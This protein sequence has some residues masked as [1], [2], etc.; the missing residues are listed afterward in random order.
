V[1]SSFSSPCPSG[2]SPGSAWSTILVGRR[3]LLA[4][5]GWLIV[6]A[7]TVG[8]FV[9]GIPAEF[10]QLQLGCPTLAC[11]STGG[12]TPVELPLLENL[13]LSPDLFAAYGVALEVI[14]ASVFVAV[15][16]LIFWRKSSDK[17]ALFV[18]LALL[19]FG[20]ATQPIAPEA[21]TFTQPVWRLPVDVLHF[22]GSACFSLFLYLFPDGRFVPRWTRWVALVWIA[23]LLPRYWFP[24]WPPSGSDT[25]LAW[26]N[27]IVW[28]SA[29]GTAVYSQAYRYRHISNTV[30]R[31]QTK[32][33]VFGIATA[34]TLFLISNLVVSAIALQSPTS[35][36]ALAELMIGAVLM[37]GALLLIPLSIGIAILRYHLFDI[38]ILINRTLVYGA[39][40]ISVVGIYV[41]VVG[42]LSL[43][44]RA[45]GG[46][47]QLVISV[48]ATGLVALLFQ[49]LRNRLQRGINRL[50]YGERDDPYAVL[51]RL[52]Q[53]LEATLAPE[54]VLPTIV[55]TV[56]ESLKLP[57]TAITLKQDDTFTVA[58]ASGIP[59]DET[60]RLPLVYQNEM[61]GQLL[62][63]QRAPGEIFSS[64]DRRLLDDLAREAGVAVHA[65]RLTTHLQRMTADLQRSREHLVNTREEERRR[66]RRDLHDGLGP[67]LASL[68]QLIDTARVLVA[69]DPDAAVTLLGD[70]KDQ[71][72]VTIT[73][74]RRLVYALR[75]PVL[76][77]LGL[78]SAIGEHIGRYNQ[79]NG[80]QVLFDAPNHLPLLPA[81][82]EVAA[83]HIA[84]EALT[85]VARHANAHTCRIR[86]WLESGLCLE[87][88]DDGDGMPMNKHAGVGLTSMR[89]RAA[90]LG[91][92]FKIEPG[93]T[94]GTRVRARLPLPME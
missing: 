25:W 69:R 28:L 15:A 2:S 60:L 22:L 7:L 12:A 42:Y 81:A 27:L 1:F 8:L 89:E 36:G 29:L 59:V 3:L 39:L 56:K 53:R 30:Q 79:P 71:I 92:E 85:N 18:S 75:P 61:V 16:A 9:A 78:V 43:L 82:V 5:A 87:I 67:T 47:S 24:D 41:L 93:T 35:T 52:G 55:E 19:L 90:E 83:Y 68:I 77:E 84:L 48:L 14:F 17:V 64:A 23:W 13:G 20:T 37:Y 46:E 74:I 70:V 49:P 34:L 10:A 72:K 57:Y 94:H 4:R 65:V 50:M 26:A 21:L 91:G 6:G 11:A 44:F 73:D 63:A 62:L 76:D 51:S 80:L 33:A 88:T 40:T 32:W 66:M 45:A 38:D 86:L 31:Q 58:A 54:S